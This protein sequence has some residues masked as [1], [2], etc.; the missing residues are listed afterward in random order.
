MAYDFDAYFLQELQHTMETAIRQLA[1]Y[2]SIQAPDLS[3]LNMEY[4]PLD[5]SEKP[6]NLSSML[7][8][9]ATYIEASYHSLNSKPKWNTDWPIDISFKELTAD[10]ASISYNPIGVV[11]YQ[12]RIWDETTDFTQAI[13]SAIENGEVA[14][15]DNWCIAAYAQDN[16]RALQALS[17]AMD[18]AGAS[19]GAKG[20][21]KPNSRV[22]QEQHQLIEKYQM[23]R[24]DKNLGIMKKLVEQAREYM[25]TALEFGSSLEKIHIEFTSSYNSFL[26]KAKQQAVEVYKLR[27]AAEIQKF[28]G[29]VKEALY[30]VEWQFSYVKQ[31]VEK[32]DNIMKTYKADVMHNKGTNEKVEYYIS[33]YNEFVKLYN[34]RM[35]II[36]AQ[37]ANK[38]EEIKYNVG[39]LELSLKQYN[40]SLGETLNGLSSTIGSASVAMTAANTATIVLNKVKKVT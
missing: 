23:N 38:V 31:E 9:V 34:A 1:L 7:N 30:A 10:I 21:R 14:F 33:A 24:E 32:I 36:K 19:I 12:E 28:E 13:T 8:D 15:W 35:G 22:K 40:K 16:L 17:D 39:K 2:K 29:I 25:Q 11:S 37:I 18:M 6:D 5:A 20:F 27:I 4:E 3:G 26:V